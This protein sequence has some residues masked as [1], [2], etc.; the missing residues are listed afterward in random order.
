MTPDAAPSTRV[1]ATP[2]IG[3]RIRSFS[4]EIHVLFTSASLDLFEFRSVA[5]GE[6]PLH[7]HQ[8]EDE[9]FYVLDGA[10]TTYVDGRER[11]AGAGELL[12]LPRGVAHTFALDTPTARVLQVNAPGGFVAMFFAI[13]AV[14]ADRDMPA[15]PGPE[16][17]ADLGPIFA[18]YQIA[19]VGSNPRYAR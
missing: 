9:W 14:F 3:D 7:V 19:V 6:P 1:D 8:R 16:H 15:A 10:L 4:D 12:H 5:G 18:R 11:Q 17:M 2:Q 13:A